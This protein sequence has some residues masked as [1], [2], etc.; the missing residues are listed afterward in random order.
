[1][2]RPDTGRT[3]ATGAKFSLDSMRTARSLSQL[4]VRRIASGMHPGMT[5]AQAHDLAMATLQKLEMERN[6]HPIIIRFGED[7]LRTFREASD[8][9]R[10]L[11][12]QD[13][14]FIDIGPVWEGHEGDAGDTFVMGDDPQMHACAEAARTLWQGVA[15]R[16]RADRLSGQALYAYAAERAETMGWRLNLDIKGHRVCDFPHAIYQAGR[17][18]DFGLCP[19]TGIWILEIQIA[20]PTLPFGAFYEDLLMANDATHDNSAAEAEPVA[21]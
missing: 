8:P 17:L 11:G 13:I 2:T 21:A 16:W 1:M 10:V 5:H 4:A 20:H 14:F 15:D 18:G 7:T 19:A 9:G 12:E 3:E 6:W